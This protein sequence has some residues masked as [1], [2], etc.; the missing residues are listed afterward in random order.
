MTNPRTRLT[1]ITSQ[2]TTMGGLGSNMR[3]LKN[4]GAATIGELREFLGKMR[5]RS[6]QEVLGAVAQSSLFR[7]TL[8]TI[9][10]TLLVMTAG[11][12]GPY[13]LVPPKAKQQAKP[14]AQAPPVQAAA[15]PAAAPASDAAKPAPADSEGKPDLKKA[16]AKMGLD[17]TKAAD[18]KSN[19]LDKDVDKLLDLK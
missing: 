19:P 13:Y 6:P 9:V 10:G 14:A 1:D 3:R 17:E 2:P 16:A 12:L 15:T 4:D 8:W 18:P 5:G 7:C 11:T